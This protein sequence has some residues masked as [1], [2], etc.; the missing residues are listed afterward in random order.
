MRRRLLT[1]VNLACLATL[2]S[3][4]IPSPAQAAPGIAFQ[5]PTPGDGSKIA[6]G[7]TIKVTASAE[8]GLYKVTGITLTITPRPGFKAG[9]PIKKTEQTDTLTYEWDTDAD[10]PYNGVYDLKAVATQTTLLGLLPQD[11]TVTR[12]AIVDNP[13]ATPSGLKVVLD[14]GIPSLTWKE[15]TEPDFTGYAVYRTIGDGAASKLGV[16]KV[17]SYKD[18]SAP[19]GQ[20][21]RYQVVAIRNSAVTSD[22]IASAPAR[23]D[24]VTIPVPEPDQPAGTAPVVPVPAGAPAIPVPSPIIAK[25]KVIGPAFVSLPKRDVGFEPALPFGTPVPAPQDFKSTTTDKVAPAAAS[26]DGEG[27]FAQVDP[28][29]FVAAGILLLIISGLLFKTSRR[30]LKANPASGTTDFELPSLLD[31]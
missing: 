10:T 23:A 29:K 9:A 11:A 5:S 13:P 16:V 30:L 15:N 7:Q 20:P 25:P 22:G 2:A 27:V 18:S 26:G 31:L 14:N 4:S 12:N 28:A 1:L 6:G 3:L 19:G 17:A 21:L 8:N 24:P